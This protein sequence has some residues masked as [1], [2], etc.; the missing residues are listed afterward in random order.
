MDRAPGKPGDPQP[1]PLSLEVAI[2]ATILAILLAIPFGTLS[3]VF[4]NTWID[5]AVRI[6]AVAGLAVPSFWLGMLI[7]LVLLINFN[8]I[9]PLTFT[10]IL[11]RPLEKPVAADLAGACSGLSLF[12]GRH[13]HDALNAARS[14]ARGLY[15]HR[16]G[17]RRL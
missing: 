9:P 5:Y 1:L 14:D 13:P 7:I 12:R 6:F 3:A 10:P 16:A 4:Q 2:L 15:P 17:Q 11:R 8:W